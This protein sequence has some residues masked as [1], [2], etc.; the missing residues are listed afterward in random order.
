MQKFRVCARARSTNAT[1]YVPPSQAPEPPL[2]PP[3][4]PGRRSAPVRDQRVAGYTFRVAASNARGV[5]SVTPASLVIDVRPPFWRTWWFGLLAAGALG[6]TGIAAYRRRIA[7]VERARA[8]QEAFSRELIASQEQERVRIASELHDSLGQSLIVIGNWAAPGTSVVPPAAP[9]REE[10]AE[11]QQAAQ[12]A[13]DEVRGI[14]HALGTH[15]L[16][17]LGLADSLEEMIERLRRSAPFEIVASLDRRDR[18]LPRDAETSLYRVAQE[19]LN[20]VSRH[21]GASQVT[22]TLRRSPAGTVTLTI[23]D[24]GRGFDHDA[25]RGGFGL[26][27]MAERVRLF[28]GEFALRSSPGGGTMV[29]VVMK[30]GA[31]AAT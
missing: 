10:L 23:G 21:A 27:D 16:E 4:V 18:P 12:R 30:S 17:Q 5:W 26:K 31:D 3:R 29:E 2:P 1:L 7:G 25:V 8:A 13:V 9:G 28:A 22:V 11:I 15:D 20:N 19:A 6:G 24:N 14:A